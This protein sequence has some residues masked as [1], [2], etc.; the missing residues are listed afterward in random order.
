M[1]QQGRVRND[2]SQEDA[3]DAHTWGEIV[4]AVVD[5][6][7]TIFRAVI[8][9]AAL[10]SKE[11]LQKSAKAGGLLGAAAILGFLAAACLTTTCIV[12]LAIVL[13][14]W[15][16]SLIVG[17]LLAGAAGGAFLLGRLALEEVDPLPQQ[18]LETLKDNIEWAKTRTR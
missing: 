11:K 18:T 2:G 13:P 3:A 15:L 16:S 4:G 14:L 10:E 17:V 12:A 9:L 8:R 7:Q 1:D 6:L 5:N